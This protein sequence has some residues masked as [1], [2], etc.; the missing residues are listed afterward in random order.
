MPSETV[1]PFAS[2]ITPLVIVLVSLPL[3]LIVPGEGVRVIVPAGKPGVNATVVLP[4]AVP[5]DALI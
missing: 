5:P 4:E 1:L 3:A 2:L